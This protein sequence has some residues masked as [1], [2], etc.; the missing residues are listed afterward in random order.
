MPVAKNLK[1][2]GVPRLEYF[3]GHEF[4]NLLGALPY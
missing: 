4:F 2:A 3:A 1:Q